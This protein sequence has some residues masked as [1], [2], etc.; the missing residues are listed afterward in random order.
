[1]KKI[2]LRG[3]TDETVPKDVDNKTIKT[4]IDDTQLTKANPIETS[5]IST[6]KKEDPVVETKTLEKN[7]NEKKR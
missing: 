4:K 6:R 7:K 5:V 1:V 3:E 2:L